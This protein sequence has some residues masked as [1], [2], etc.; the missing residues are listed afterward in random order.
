LLQIVAPVT[1]AGKKNSCLATAG[2]T[3]LSLSSVY[4]VS[5]SASNATAT[6][7]ADLVVD[8]SDVFFGTTDGVFAC[9]PACGAG[10]ITQ[11]AAIEAD[12]LAL[13]STRVYF[14]SIPFGGAP[15]VDAVPRAGGTP[16][17]LATD[18]THPIGVTTDA[19]YVYFADAGDTANPAD[20]RVVR[21]PLTGCTA[22]TET[23]LSTGDNPRAVPVDSK[24][25]YWGTQSGAIWR[26]AK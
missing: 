11:G 7:L 8:G 19:T 20:G 9:T 3:P 5:A 10:A 4:V 15:T 21:C 14:T 22:S 16:T 25:V 23:T 1:P 2:T 6:L 26:L 18:V 17:V 12:T 13:D 24:A